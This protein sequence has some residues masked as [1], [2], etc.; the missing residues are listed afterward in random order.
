MIKYPKYLLLSLMVIFGVCLESYSQTPQPPLSDVE[1]QL[2]LRA[3]NEL[4]SLRTQVKGHEEFVQREL[5]LVQREKQS[6]EKLMEAQTRLLSV[7]EKER[8][9]AIEKAKF[10]EDAL[11]VVTKKP[12]GFKRIMC[13]IC[14]LGLGRCD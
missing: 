14:T 8:D 3:F 4:E 13:K 10:Y 5:E 12:G 11:K 9:L 7:T 1:K 6:Y 2:I